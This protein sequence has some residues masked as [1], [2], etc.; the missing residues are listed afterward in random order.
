MLVRKD[1]WDLR[2]GSEILVFVC[3][4]FEIMRSGVR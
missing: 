3:A 1:V 4:G 2:W